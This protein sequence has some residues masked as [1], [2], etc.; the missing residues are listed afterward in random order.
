MY[1]SIGRLLT[2]NVYNAVMKES[3]LYEKL[4]N[5]KVK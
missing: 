2:K 4:A 5:D 1:A 3:L